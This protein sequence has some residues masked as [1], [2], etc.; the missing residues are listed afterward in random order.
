LPRAE[1]PG[2]GNAGVLGS[3]AGRWFA[4][5]ICHDSLLSESN[6]KSSRPEVALLGKSN[7]SFMIRRLAVAAWSC[8][9]GDE[10]AVEIRM[11]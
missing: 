6:P 3:K 1:A 2:T 9:D 7:R 5:W 10:R 11:E 8:G 4:Q